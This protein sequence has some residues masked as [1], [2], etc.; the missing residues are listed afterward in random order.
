MAEIKNSRIPRTISLLVTICLFSLPAYAKY[1][2]GSGMADDPYQIATARDLMLLGESPEDYDKYFILTADID[3]DP[4]LPDGKVFDKAVIAPDTSS[5]IF[6][7]GGRFTGLFDGNGH[8]ISHLTVTGEDY[9]GLFG[10]LASDAKIKNLGVVDIDITGND[11]IGGL[12][13]YNLASDIT[14]C[15]ST[16]TVRGNSDVGGLAGYTQGGNITCSFSTTEVSGSLYVGGLVGS[17]VAT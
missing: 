14:R 4:K 6:F 8:V 16:G 1:S 2:G 15:Y 10:E 7:Q 12:V 11:K 9:L 3:L 17:S 5:S 13:G